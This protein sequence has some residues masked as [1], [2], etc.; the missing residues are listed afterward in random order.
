MC[1]IKNTKLYDCFNYSVC[2]EMI[3]MSMT[4]RDYPTLHLDTNS[5]KGTMLLLAVLHF[6]V[7]V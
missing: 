2:K 1:Y 5:S 3:F 7:T 4:I 6:T